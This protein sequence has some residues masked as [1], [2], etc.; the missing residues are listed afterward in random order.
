MV[1]PL[2]LE[3]QDIVSKLMWGLGIELGSSEEQQVL[4][5]AEPSS[6]HPL[7][8]FKLST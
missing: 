6:L 3:V 7:R 1:I 8:Q 4:L 2:E 5:T